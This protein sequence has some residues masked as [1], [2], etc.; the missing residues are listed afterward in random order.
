MRPRDRLLTSR[1]LKTRNSKIRR[2]RHRRRTAVNTYYRRD[3]CNGSLEANPHI[4]RY[5]S[6]WVEDGVVYL[7]LE[8]CQESLQK[9]ID[10]TNVETLDEQTLLKIMRQILEGL[11]HLHRNNV[12]HMDI[13][14]E[15]SW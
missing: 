9:Y 6:A 4:T 7:V 3:I 8:L 10:S 14:P 15:T 12:V 11:Q 2:R 13:K 1:Q 5:Y